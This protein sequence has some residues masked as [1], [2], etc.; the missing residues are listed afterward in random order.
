MVVVETTF[1][2][3]LSALRRDFSFPLTLLVSILKAIHSWLDRMEEW[4]QKRAE[5]LEK[6]RK[7]TL[8]E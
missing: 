1:L 6:K 4:V 3:S 7:N 8:E 2:F 5:V